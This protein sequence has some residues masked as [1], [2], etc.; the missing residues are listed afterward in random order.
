M[1]LLILQTQPPNSSLANDSYG[2]IATAAMLD[3]EVTIVYCGEGLKQLSDTA[4]IEQLENSI[5]FGVKN[6]YVC[7]FDL[8]DIQPGTNIQTIKAEQVPQLIQ[9]SKT[10]LSF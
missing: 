2:V 9:Q 4:L 10:V 8:S 1:S 3:Q 5:E 6:V 7:D